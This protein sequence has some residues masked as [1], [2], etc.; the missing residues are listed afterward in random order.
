MLR[1]PIAIELFAG[2]GGMST[3]LLDAG[4][5]VAAGFDHEKRAIEGYAYNHEY[6]GSRGFVCDLAKTSGDELLSLA[7]VKGIDLLAGGPPCQPFSV[8]GKRH[9]MEDG[10]GQLVY[11]F[12][13]FIEQL[14]PRAVL[15]ENVANLAT[16]ND[17]AILSLIRGKLERWGYRVEARVCSA[18]DYG[19][20]QM[21]KRLLV[22]AARDLDDLSFPAPTHGSQ[23]DLFSAK[24]LFPHVTA[25]EALRDLPDAAD[26]GKC[27]IYNHEPTKHSAQMLSRLRRLRPGEREPGSFHD[28]LHPDRP[29]FT[30]RAGTGN[31]SP[32]RPIHYRY[33]RVITARESA[34]L[35]GFSD[36]FIWPDWIPRLQQYR[37]VGNAVPP[38]VARAMAMHLA[39]KLGW[40]LSAASCSG[41]PKSRP[42]AITLT[43]AERKRA[44]LSRIRGASLGIPR[45]ARARS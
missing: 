22:L 8:V 7:G 19:V 44:R 26:F 11:D 25:S 36:D 21:R 29:S 10:R 35:Q 3:G 13:R 30:L 4:I 5:R 14:Q 31:F 18:A 15:F 23:N 39:R 24:K 33:N 2:C 20:P 40:R 16:I 37:Q 12:L 1:S 34:R 42:S 27:G 45:T 38:P 9:G 43:D 17:G 32:L 28:R 6:R 41:D